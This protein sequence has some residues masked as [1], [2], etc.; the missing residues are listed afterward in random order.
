MP[1]AL[2]GLMADMG[3]DPQRSSDLGGLM[4][5]MGLVRVSALGLGL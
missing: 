2:G 4:A 1:D 3:E 5:D